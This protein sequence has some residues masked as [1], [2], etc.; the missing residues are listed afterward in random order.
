MHLNLIWTQPQSSLREAQWIRWLFAD[1]ETVEHVAPTLEIFADNSIYVLS[2]NR[3]PLSTLPHWFFERLQRVQGK[4]LFHLSD[5]WFSGGYQVY[6]NFDFVL[7]NYYSSLFITPGIKSLPL[8]PASNMMNGACTRR[9]SGRDVIWSF[10]GQKTALRMKM[11][12]EFKNLRP[13][14]CHFFNSRSQEKPPLGQDALASLL[15]HTIFAP[16]PM[17]NVVLETFRVYEALEMGCIPLVERRKWMPYYDLL[18]PGHPLP[19]FSNWRSARHFVEA[20]LTDRT[21]LTA[22]QNNIAQWWREFKMMLRKDV[23]SFVTEGLEGTFQASLRNEWH[24]Q[25]GLRHAAWRLFEL[26]KHANRLS[27]QDRIAITARRII[28]R[29]AT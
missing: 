10:A 16:C 6:S 9:T 26:S 11:F 17:G 13:N 22:R 21:E 19:T 25:V 27:L 4:G 5:E 14:E 1:F 8:G 18:L 28:E 29:V 23:T 12:D 24:C 15:C 2:S 7:R 20:L 3:H